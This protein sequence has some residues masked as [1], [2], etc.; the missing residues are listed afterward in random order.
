MV[1][2]KVS[3]RHLIMKMKECLEM[4]LAVL[5]IQVPASHG[6][7]STVFGWQLPRPDQEALCNYGVP[8]SVPNP[9]GIHLVGDIQVGTEPLLR[10][11]DKPAY[12]LGSQLWRD[13]AAL[14]VSGEVLAV[15][16]AQSSDF[17]VAKVVG[18]PPVRM[19]SSVSTFLEIAWR[20]HFLRPLLLASDYGEAFD[21]GSE[22]FLEMLPVLDM[23]L[24]DEKAFPWWRDLMLSW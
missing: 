1:G 13:I 5:N 9:H 2:E 6:R 7:S 16:P 24:T 12:R 19:N 21:L 4:P 3:Q 17:F 15:P 10:V 20:W 18:T 11:G 22:R 23:A 14:A 8:I